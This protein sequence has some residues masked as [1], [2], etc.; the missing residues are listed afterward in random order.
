[1]KSVI[2]VGTKGASAEVLRAVEAQAKANGMEMQIA[3]GERG[4]MAIPQT[5][6]A[7]PPFHMVYPAITE[8]ANGIYVPQKHT[9]ATPAMQKR[10]SKKSR[11]K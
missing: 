2:I 5:T 4:I 10:A 9:H 3:E 11:R 6:I 1:M 7:P 8:R